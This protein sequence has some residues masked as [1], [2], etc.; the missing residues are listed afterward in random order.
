MV[1]TPTDNKQDMLDAI[2]RF[3]LQRATAT[4][5]GLILA[6]AMLFP[7]EGIDIETVIANSARSRGYPG[8]AVPIDAPRK[9]SRRK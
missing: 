3:Q 9:P 5:S 1:Q 7:E 8:G 2:D 6:L 4:G